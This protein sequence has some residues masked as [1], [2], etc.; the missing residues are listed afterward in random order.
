MAGM[1]RRN[2]SHNCHGRNGVLVRPGMACYMPVRCNAA[3]YHTAVVARLVA[4]GSALRAVGRIGDGAG[5]QCDQRGLEIVAA[6]EGGASRSP[7]G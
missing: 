2:I 3:S 6:V 5:G 4:A 1:T 7:G